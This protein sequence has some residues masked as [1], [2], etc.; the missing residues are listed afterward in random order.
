MSV[1][2]GS[3]SE[4]PLKTDLLTSMVFVTF[5]PSSNTKYIKLASTSNDGLTSIW[6]LVLSLQETT[7]KL[8]VN[9]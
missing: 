8:Q 1:R 9:R 5:L 4:R 7:L 6:R 2:S 3:T